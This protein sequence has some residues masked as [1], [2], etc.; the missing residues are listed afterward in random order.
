MLSLPDSINIML[1]YAGYKL[2]IVIMLSYW[3][4]ELRISNSASPC[5]LIKVDK[6]KKVKKVLTFIFNLLNQKSI[7]CN[8]P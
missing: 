4:L 7:N 2:Y 3:D 8:H 6:V 5:D 1:L